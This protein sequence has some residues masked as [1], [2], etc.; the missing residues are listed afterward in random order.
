[1]DNRYYKYN[2]PALMN[3]GRFLTS[4]VRSRVFDQYIRNI[5]NIN[6]GNDYKNFLQENGNSIINNLKAFH[7]QSDTC[8]VEGQCL[9][10]SGPTQDNMNDYLN[11]SSQEPKSEWY[12]QI[13]SNS[14]TESSDSTNIFQEQEDVQ[15]YDNLNA[16]KANELSKQIYNNML[17]QNEQN[18]LSAEKNCTFCKK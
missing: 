7:R 11:G 17:V 18:N 6:T 14:N 9:P 5:N 8:K 10:M 2:C 4:H 12:D 13:T 16:K 15:N 3:D 1:M